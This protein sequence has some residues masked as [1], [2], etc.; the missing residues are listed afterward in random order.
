MRIILLQDIKGLGKKNDIKNISDGY[1]RNFLIP[2]KLAKIAT[3]REAREI[4]QLK[5]AKEG[6]KEELVNRLKLLSEEINETQLIFYP[7]IGK[8]KEIYSSVTKEDIKSA[9]AEKFIQENKDK[10]FE[11][12]EIELKKPIRNIGEHV[13]DADL[14]F[15]IKAKIKAV[16]S[17]QPL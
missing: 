15:G 13:I 2:K 11:N 12:T 7:K 4:K 10:I 3:D 16:L 1:G 6:Q 9:L 8:N 14:G 17:D 5:E